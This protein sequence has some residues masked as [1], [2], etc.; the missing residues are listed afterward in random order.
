MIIMKG[1]NTYTDGTTV[2]CQI[3]GLWRFPLMDGQM[4]ILVYSGSN[5]TLSPILDR[6]KGTTN[7]DS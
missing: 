3:I 6:Q 4:D 1:E 5:V 7:I 2:R